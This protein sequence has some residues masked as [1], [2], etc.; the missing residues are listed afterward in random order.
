VNILILN[1][2]EIRRCAGL[3]QEAV[4][5]VALGFTRLT[6]GRVSLPP[7][8]RVDIPSARGEVDIKT[9]YID[10]LERFAVK[11]ASGFFGNPDIGLPY[12][13]GL[14]LL[15]SARTGL[16]EAVLLDN[17][18]LTD[19]RTGIAGAIAA[20]HLAP[21][22]IQT[23]GVVGTGVQARFQMRALRLVR[24]FSRIAVYGRNEAA[25]RRYVGEMSAELGVEVQPMPDVADVVRESQ[26]V[27]TT[28]PTREPWLRAEWLHPG[29]H[30]TA[31]GAD[32]EHKQE[33]H[34][35]VFAR[36]DRIVCDSLKQC[37][38]LGELHHA[39]GAGVLASDHPVTEIGALTSGVAT[40]RERDA[41]ITVCDLTGV[42]VQDTTIAVQVHGKAIELGLGSS[43]KV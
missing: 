18:Y 42:G 36:A 8:V 24:D 31:V 25:V 33:L 21:R 10:G 20:Q 22:R 26:V 1:E 14:M 29:L 28:T 32:G 13:S 43:F 9:A 12:G 6:E 2:A 39:Y 35:D 3:T 30:I 40:G 4:A 17:G 15:M 27:V 11:V 23:A 5:A 34:A 19:L 7:I 16:L 41:E 37:S 38:R